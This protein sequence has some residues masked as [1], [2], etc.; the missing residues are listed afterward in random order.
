MWVG[1]KFQ[2]NPEIA[3]SPRN[4]F[5]ASRQSLVEVEALNFPR[6]RQSLPK[7]IKLRIAMKMLAGVRLARDN[8]PSKRERAQTYS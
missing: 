7:D 3:G 1:E 2:S 4:S 6:G 5:R 8:G